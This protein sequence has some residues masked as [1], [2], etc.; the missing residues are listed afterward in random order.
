MVTHHM[1]A[2]IKQAKPNDCCLQRA[3]RSGLQA[4]SDFENK[5]VW[6]PADTTH[7]VRA[8]LP[9]LASPIVAFQPLN[10]P[11]PCTSDPPVIGTKGVEVCTSAA[12]TVS[13]GGDDTQRGLHRV[14]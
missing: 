9:N 14:L 12:D 7:A 5:H 3:A 11:A 6:S 2:K 4:T 8:P 13:T 1:V 10:A